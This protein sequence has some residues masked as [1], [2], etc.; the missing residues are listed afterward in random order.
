M[1]IDL[2]STKILIVDD[3]E[4]IR[5]TFEIFL[6]SAGYRHVKTASS[7][8]EAI[9]EMSHTSYDLVISDIVLRGTGG[10][11]LLREIRKTGVKCPVVMITGFP[12]LESATE[13]LRYGA[14]DYISK[15]V[16]KET[17]LRF[18]RLALKQWHLEN[19]TISLQEENDRCLLHLKTI[20]HSVCD[21]IITVDGNLQIIQLNETAKSLLGIEEDHGL[22]DLGQLPV[23]VY[24]ACL[25]DASH[26]LEN[27]VE[28]RQHLI[29]CTFPENKTNLLSLN[30]SPLMDQNKEV[31][32]VVFVIRDL[33]IE[34]PKKMHKKRTRFHGYVGPSAAMQKVYEL[35]ENL[36]KVDT[37][38]LITGES[39]TGKELAAEALHAESSRRDKPLIKVDCVSVAEDLLESELFGHKKGAFTGADKDRDGRLLQADGG[40]LFLDEIGDISP[41]TQLLFFYDSYRKEP[42]HLLVRMSRYMWTSESSLQPMLTSRKR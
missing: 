19:K 42:L 37:A 31:Q 33:T 27:G 39:G 14:F 6:S 5:Q 4:S 35:I 9:E 29:E 24:Q 26:V 3:E 10:T 38:V 7:F 17:L 32:G 40:T 11:D 25:D 20:F 12:N 22:F 2:Y 8:D 36:G 15:P 30:A 34:L 28:V 13:S 16:N 23:E 18:T 21:S 1:S 41:R